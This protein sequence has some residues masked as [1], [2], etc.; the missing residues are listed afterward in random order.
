[1]NID[2]HSNRD[3]QALHAL[4]DGQAPGVY[5]LPDAILEAV[6]GIAT[7]DAERLRLAALAGPTNVS[8]QDA[9]AASIFDRL[10]ADAGIGIVAEDALAPH[11]DMI[12]LHA[13][14]T[15]EIALHTRSW[16][17]WSAQLVERVRR[18]AEP[19][20]DVLG[21]ATDHVLREAAPIAAE[22]A[23]FR[24]GDP[25]ALHRASK[26]AIAA[27]AAAEPLVVRHDAVRH[28]AWG[29]VEIV[30]PRG[31]S[32]GSE[33]RHDA[34]VALAYRFAGGGIE[35]RETEQWFSNDQGQPTVRQAKL[36]EVVWRPAGHPVE[37]LV[38]AVAAAHREPVDVLDGRVRS[39]TVAAR[40]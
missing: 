3:D 13:R 12:A 16:K 14:L 32:D 30:R 39:T 22:L 38:R 34:W 20:A 25:A 6:T 21:T 40:L 17:Y 29:F 23:G 27:F 15:P 24:F 9:L 18:D 7:S 11:R 10:A 33:V 1:M 36:A 4:I 5:T 37:R 28:A 2:T 8:A 35:L 31:G 19:I 26:A